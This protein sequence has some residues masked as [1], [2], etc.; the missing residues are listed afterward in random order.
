MPRK[1][2][3][4]SAGGTGGHLYPAQEI[5][6]QLAPHADTLFVGGRLAGSPFFDQSFPFQEIPCATFSLRKPA[7]VLAGCPK[8][9]KGV[10]AS[11]R[12]LKAFQPD[13]VVGFGSFF[14]LP[15][16]LAARLAGVPIALHEQ[17]TV[18]GKVNTLFSRTAKVTG[19]TFP[20]TADYLKGETLP[21]AF[22]VR[23]FPEKTRTDPPTLMIMGGSQGAQRLNTLALQALPLLRTPVHV[24]HY[25]GSEPLAKQARAVYTKCGLLHEVKPFEPRITEVYARASLALCRAGAGTIAELMASQTPA[26]LVPF[27]YATHDHQTHNARFFVDT[28]GGGALIPENELTAQRLADTLESM[29]SEGCHA[30]NLADYTQTHAPQ[31]FLD[32]LLALC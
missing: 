11:R 24:C 23:S 31:N 20:K 21:V 26:L 19:I 22:P 18:P 16:L 10:R 25:T 1:R 6:R 29:L 12:I 28:V 9:W 13:L 5:A 27:P 32:V 8:L 17:N 2:I 3:I 14:S 30:Q 7:T 15:M 4:L